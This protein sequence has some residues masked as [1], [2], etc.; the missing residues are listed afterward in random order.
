MRLHLLVQKA[1]KTE[2]RSPSYVPN[3]PTNYSTPAIQAGTLNLPVL[4]AN[5]HPIEIAAAT[6]YLHIAAAVAC[7]KPN[8]EARGCLDHLVHLMR[9]RGV[10]VAIAVAKGSHLFDWRHLVRHGLVVAAGC[11]RDFG[12]S[13][14]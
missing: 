4:A 8:L 11:R 1:S 5:C 3:L 10:A 14:W 7:L 2:S 13:L 9:G 12:I 6:K